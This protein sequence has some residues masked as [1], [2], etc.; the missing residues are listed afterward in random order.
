MNHTMKCPKC[1]AWADWKLT[2]SFMLFLVILSMHLSALAYIEESAL[3]A[4]S[5]LVAI[6]CIV[7]LHWY[8]CG[9]FGV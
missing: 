7:F 8:I 5:A 9:W 4:W 6:L 3:C 1:G 2:E